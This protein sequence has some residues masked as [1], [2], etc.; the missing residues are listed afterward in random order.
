MTYGRIGLLK[1]LVG[2][3]LQ[4]AAVDSRL[5]S[6]EALDGMVG[7]TT[8]S[9]TSM[10]NYLPL[11]D[12]SLGIPD[13]HIHTNIYTCIQRKTYNITVKVKVDPTLISD[14][15]HVLMPDT[16]GLSSII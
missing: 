2:Q 9:G 3:Q 5:G 8:V 11:D 1:D 10:E 14:I 7:F 16:P 12:T 4:R 15:T 13:D 6:Q